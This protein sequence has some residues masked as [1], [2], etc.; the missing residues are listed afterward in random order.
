M[1]D[2]A[3]MTELLLEDPGPEEQALTELQESTLINLM[4]CSVKQ[5]A[6]GIHPLGRV[7]RSKVMASGK[8]S[9][10]NHFMTALP[11]LLSKYQRND[12]IIATLLSIPLY[13]DLKLYATTRQQNSL[14]SL[15]DILKATVENH[16]SSE[17]TDVAAKALETLCLNERLTSSKTEG[18]LLQVLEAVSTSLLSS[19]RS[20][21]ESIANVSLMLYSTL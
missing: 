10:T 11:K 6:T 8:L 13:F 7:P 15:L 16:S 1:K 17:V 3:T 20:Y 2:W 21:E 5:A 4:T 9:V 18:S 12:K 14:E 19:N